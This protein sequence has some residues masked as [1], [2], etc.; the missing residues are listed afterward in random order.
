MPDENNAAGAIDNKGTGEEKQS[1]GTDEKKPAA[2]EG[3]VN[4]GAGAGNGDKGA[5]EGGADKKDAKA[6]IVDKKDDKETTDEFVDDGSEPD[7]KDR[8]SPKDF[9]IQR[10]NKKIAS[11]EANKDKKT[12]DGEENEDEEEIAPEDEKLINRVVSKTFA[13]II[14][15]TIAADDDKEIT[16]FLTENPDF[17][18]FEAKARRFIA[19]PSRRHLPVKA[20]F[21][22]VAGDQLI[23][24][25]AKREQEATKKAKDTQTGGGSNR[26]GGGEPDAWQLTPDEFEAKQEKIRQGQS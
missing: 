13:P 19:H 7:T 16:K 12:D 17:K 5:P 14:D 11:L 4:A 18:P 3:D 8:M 23:K 10:K 1:A 22:E 6:P 21:Y 15:K 20:V 9:I 26:G 2:G 25:G 24:I